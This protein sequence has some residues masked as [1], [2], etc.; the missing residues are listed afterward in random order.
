MTD[1]AKSK[2]VLFRP[3]GKDRPPVASIADFTAGR[4]VIDGR[5]T[6]Y[7]CQDY[8]CRLPTTDPAQMMKMVA[9]STGGTR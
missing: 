7:V 1:G 3:E 9:E 8:I 5:T 4:R 2:V 6:A